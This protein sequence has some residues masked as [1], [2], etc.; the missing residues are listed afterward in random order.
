[1]FLKKAFVSGNKPL[2]I[3]TYNRPTSGRIQ[4]NNIFKCQRTKMERSLY[5]DY[6]LTLFFHSRCRKY[7]FTGVQIYINFLSI[8]LAFA[9]VA[10]IDSPCE[11]NG[12]FINGLAA[13]TFLCDVLWLHLFNFY[14]HRLCFI[15][16]HVLKLEIRPV[17]D[18]KCFH[19]VFTD[20]CIYS[21]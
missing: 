18:Y 16:Q 1:M 3:R 4:T 2:T 20:V 17:S 9:I 8:Q 14:S 5:D 6:F 11:V 10:G 12:F 15:L 21:E 13:I 19:R 7:V